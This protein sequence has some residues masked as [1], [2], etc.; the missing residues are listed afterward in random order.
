MVLQ[1]TGAI[2]MSSIRN[3]FGGPSTVGAISMSQYKVGGAYVGTIAA[4]PNNIPSTNSGISASKFYSAAKYAYPA[5]KYPCQVVTDSTG[6]WGMSTTLANNSS[7]IWTFSRAGFAY[8]NPIVNYRVIFKKIF[9][10][11]TGSDI[12]GTIYS[13]QDNTMYIYLNNINVA[14]YTWTNT[15]N[16]L[17]CTS[18]VG[19]NI[20]TC[21]VN[22]EGGGAIFRLALLDSGNTKIIGTDSSW[23]MDVN[24]EYHFYNWYGLMTQYS[25]GTYTGGTQG[26]DPDVQWKL[27][28]S[29][30]GT[31][32]SI[33]IN[34]RLQD[35]TSFAM[36]FEIFIQNDSQADGLTF[37]FGSTNYG[38]G[39]ESGGGNAYTLSFRLFSNRG[40]YLYNNTTQVQSYATTAHIASSWQPVYVYYNNSTTNTISVT[41]NG[42]N[43][44]TYNNASQSSW[45]SSS[46]PYWGFM[47]RDGG[48]V[49]SAWVRHTH[50]MHR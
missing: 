48:S 10:N 8:V 28:N 14:N 42:T 13:F 27:G 29:V 17:A 1:S 4:N 47:F 16:S 26:S 44:Y 22:D 6:T 38:G 40:I 49:G 15:T 24:T 33:Y 7:P 23:Y 12:S 32:N 50:I 3:E 37:Y 25:V 5:T 34:S 35:Y 41:W 31:Y 39:D 21:G 46:G 20:I 18:Q 30:G 19:Q 43:I 45:L 36:Y 2:S 11:A 9:Q